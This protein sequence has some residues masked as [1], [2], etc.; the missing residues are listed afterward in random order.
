MTKPNVASKHMLGK[1]Q[2][3][4]LD[5]RDAVGQA[6]FVERLFDVAA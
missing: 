1:G 3:E 2:V 6:Q 5:G 4:R